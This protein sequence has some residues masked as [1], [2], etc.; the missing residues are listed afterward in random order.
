M[1]VRCAVRDAAR[2]RMM[3][4]YV[5][6]RPLSHAA[7]YCAIVTARRFYNAPIYAHA[8]TRYGACD[9]SAIAVVAVQTYCAADSRAM[10]RMRADI[11]IS[12]G[13]YFA[14]RHTMPRSSK[15][16]LRQ[17]IVALIS[18]TARAYAACTSHSMRIVLLLLLQF[19]RAIFF[20]FFFLMFFRC[21]IIFIFAYAIREALVTLHTH[22]QIALIA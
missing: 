21:A 14:T 10:T 1:R 15:T 6:E 18:A 4:D 16:R 19:L 5:D 17:N 20:F 22:A 7:F 12:T 8:A 13:D 11:F 3:H 9:G 2:L